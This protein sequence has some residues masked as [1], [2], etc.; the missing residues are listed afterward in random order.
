MSRNN[1]AW[2]IRRKVRRNQVQKLVLTVLSMFSIFFALLT[3]SG[4]LSIAIAITSLSAAIPFLLSRKK[5]H[6]LTQALDLS[7]PEAI[8]SLVSALQSGITIPEAVCSLASRGPLPLRSLFLEIEANLVDGNEFTQTLLRAKASANSAIADQVFET[9]IF[10]KDFGGKDSNAALRLL[11][12][13]VRE[14]LAVLEEIRTKFGWIKNSANLAAVAP[15]LLLLLL[16]T[17]ESTREAFSTPAGI[18]VLIVGLLFTGIAYVWME[19]VGTLPAM[20]RALR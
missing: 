4:T 3:I 15:W 18:K 12:E 6:A 19:R 13:F 7:W 20:D 9:L 5:S 8:D 17:Q 16:S 14:D 1:V 11:S 10:A 2:E